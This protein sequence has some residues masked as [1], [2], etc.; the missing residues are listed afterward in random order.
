MQGFATALKG[1]LKPQKLKHQN[2]DKEIYVLGELIHNSQVINEL[3][4]LGIKTVDELPELC[5]EKNG[6]I[7]VIRSHS[8]G[9]DV[10][11]D[12]KNKGYELV[13][14]TCPD[15]KKRFRIERFSWLKKIIL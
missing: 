6:A 15:V 10:F 9:Y 13:D 8:A 7:C 11:E 12:I 4:E 2:P 3:K 14:L 1:R 5:G